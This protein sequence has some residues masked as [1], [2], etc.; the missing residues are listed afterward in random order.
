MAEPEPPAGAWML[1]P[2]VVAAINDELG[3]RSRADSRLC[4]TP[5]RSSESPLKPELAAAI[6]D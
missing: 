1:P 6:A 3:S 2:A 4:S 5:L